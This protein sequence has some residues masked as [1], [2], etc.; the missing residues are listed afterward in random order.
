MD[1]IKDTSN[2]SDDINV[3]KAKESN[4]RIINAASDFVAYTDKITSN[5]KSFPAYA[6]FTTVKYLRDT[7]NEICRCLSDANAISDKT[8]TSLQKR[9]E[10]QEQAIRAIV[11]MLLL[12][13]R[14]QLD[15]YIDIKRR[16]YWGAKALEIKKAVLC[17]YN[18]DRTRYKI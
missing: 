3:N 11:Y 6:R 8:I 18:T 9:L 1:I 17:W 5:K 14:A 4:F 13:E 2:Q 12:I 10:Y 15:G 7:A 16:Q